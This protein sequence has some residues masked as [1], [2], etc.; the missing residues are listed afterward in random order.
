MAVL[1]RFDGVEIQV[2]M[3]EKEEEETR[4][5]WTRF[6]DTIEQT[7]NA[8]VYTIGISQDLGLEPPDDPDYLM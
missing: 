4:S 8:P 6:V 3:L 7:R 5:I 2:E 1:T